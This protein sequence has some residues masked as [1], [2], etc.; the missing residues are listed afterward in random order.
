[1]MMTVSRLARS[2][3]YRRVYAYLARWEGA[4]VVWWVSPSLLFLAGQ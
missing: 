4:W 2:R 3:V 1:M